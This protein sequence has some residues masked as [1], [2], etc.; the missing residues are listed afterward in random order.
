MYVRAV[1]CGIVLSDAPLRRASGFLF[2]PW[3]W[4]QSQ[5]CSTTNSPL[6]TPFLFSIRFFRF[7]SKPLT[8]PPRVRSTQPGHRDFGQSSDILGSQTAIRQLIQMV[9]A[10]HVCLSLTN[11]DPGL[12]DADGKKQVLGRHH[13]MTFHGPTLASKQR[14]SN[15]G[16]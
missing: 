6:L 3:R 1:I 11:P 5:T 8:P 4:P 14:R 7:C 9:A 2:Q 12:E 10:T 15:K 13:S 16:R